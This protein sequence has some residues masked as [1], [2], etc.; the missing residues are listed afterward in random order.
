MTSISTFND[1]RQVVLITGC[2]SGLG[3]AMAVEFDSLPGYRV[4]ATARNLDSIRDLPSGIERVQLDVTDRDSIDRAIANITNETRGRIDILINNAGTNTAVGPLIDVD[5]DRVRKTFEPNFF[6]LIMVTQAVSPYMIR[7]RSG[8][9]VNIGSTAGLTAL[10]FGATYSASKA[11]VHALS[12]ALRLELRGFG[13]KVV[14]VAPGAIKSSIADAGSKDLDF[15]A[16]SFY[17]DVKD[18]IEYR[19]N[20]SQL[21]SPTPS[22]VFAR[23]VR[24]AVTRPN[25][26]A[27]LVTGKRSFT[28]LLAYYLP[29]WI[30]DLLVGRMFSIWRIG[31]STPKDKRV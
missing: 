20:F 18:L 25:P 21:G 31:R 4:F 9:I 30:K 10:P 27:Y 28:A 29:V 24:R 22:A 23:N 2:S 5:V 8:V 14:V 17:G 19:A 1:T 13:V 26:S 7:R 15:P 6:G 12:D 11:A 16:D 3:R